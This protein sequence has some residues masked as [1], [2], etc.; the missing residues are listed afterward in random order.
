MALHHLQYWNEDMKTLSLPTEQLC[1][2]R[3]LTPLDGGRRGVGVDVPE[4]LQ[5]EIRHSWVPRQERI[6]QMC[7]NICAHCFWNLVLCQV[8][9][10]EGVSSTSCYNVDEHLE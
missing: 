8:R 6:P 7:A 5:C 9:S 2:H 1:S 3:L 10:S 4:R